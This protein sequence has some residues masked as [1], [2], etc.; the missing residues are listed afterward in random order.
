MPLKRQRNPDK[1]KEPSLV[2]AIGASAG[3]IKVIKELLKAVQKI[4]SDIVFVL[5]QHLEQSGRE[6]AEETLKTFTKLPITEIANGVRLEPGGLYWVPPHTLAQVSK[7]VFKISPARTT[8]QK[9]SVID[10]LFS[11]IGKE[12]KSRSVG[13][14]LSGEGSDGAIGLRN[15]NEAGGLTIVQAPE[16]SEFKSMPE[17]AVATATV[18]HVVPPQEI[19]KLLERNIEYLSAVQDFPKNEN[20]VH[21]VGSALTTICQILFEHTKQD[22][23]HY[24]TSTL[25]RRIQRRMQVLRINT[26]EAYIDRLSQDREEAECLFKELLINVTCFFRD[27]DSFQTLNDE[28]LVDLIKNRKA[29][30]KIR[31]WIAGCSTGEEAYTFAILLREMTAKLKNQPEI[32]ILATDIDSQAL[33]LARRGSYPATIAE[34][35]PA[36]LLNKYFTKRAGRYHVNKELREMV[37]FSIHNLINDP[38]F[39]QLDLISCRN[40]LIYLGSHL[41]KKLFPVFHYALKPNGYLFLGNSESLTSHRELFKP[42]NSK[43]RIAQ[44]KATAIKVPT[45][46]P[47]SIQSYLHQIQETPKDVHADVTMVAQRIALDEMSVKYAVVNE[48]GHIISASEGIGKYIEISGGPFQ[49]NL[50]KLT[51]GSL[52]SVLRRLMATAKAEKRKCVDESSLLKTETGMERVG[53]VVQPMPQLGEESELYWIAFQYLGTVQKVQAQSHRESSEGDQE[54]I[55]QLEREVFVLREQLE[56]SVQD[57]EA[58]NEEL[59][60][61]N[62]ELLSMNEELQAANEELETSKEEVQIANEALQRANIDLENLLAGTQIATLFLDDDLKIRGFTPA[63]TDIYR[64]QANDVGRDIRDF[65][66]HALQ[67]EPFPDPKSV[68]TSVPVESEVLMADGTIYQ[69]RI[70]P[71]TGFEGL[72]E[73]VVVTFIDVT[74]VRNIERQYRELADSMPNI[75]WT[76]TPEGSTDYLNERWYEFTGFDRNLRGESSWLPILHPEDAQR[77]LQA[78]KASLKNGTPFEI[79][80]RFW[81]KRTSTYRWFLGR[82]VP[83]KDQDG[84]IKKWIGTAIDIHDR[85]IA[86]QK[87]RESDRL[88]QLMADTA[89]VLIWI[90]DPAKQRT[91]L[92]KGWIDFTGQTLQQAL[93][94]GWREA[95]HPDDLPLYLSVYEEHSKKRAPFYIEYKLR[96][97]NGEYRWIGAR[98]VPRFAPDGTFEGYIGACLDIHEQKIAAEEIAENRRSLELMIRTSPSFMCVL[99]GPNYT[100]ETVNDQYL[101]L[102]GNRDV[103]GKPIVEALPEVKGQGFIELLD[104]VRTTGKPF[105]G[106]ELPILLQTTADGVV[107]KRYLDFVYQPHLTV[108]GQ[109][110]QIFVHGVDVT[111]KKLAR[112]LI[113]NERENFRNLFKQTPEM[114]CILSGPEHRFE[115]VNE[116]HVRVLGFDATGMTVREAQPESVEVHGILDGVYKTGKTAELREIPVTVTDRLR[117]FNLTYAARRDQEGQTNGIM[118]LGTEV[119]EE[120]LSRGELQKAKQEAENANQMKTLFLANIS[121]EIRTPLAAIFGFSDIL[122]SS[123]LND[124]ESGEYVERISRNAILLRKIIDDLL[125]L[126]KIESDKLEIEWLQADVDSLIEDIY[127]TVQLRAEHKG[128]ELKF[129]WLTAKPKTILTDPLRLSQVLTN[130]IGNAVKFTDKGSIQVD[131]SASSSQLKVRIADTGIGMTAEQQA[132]IFQPFS[133][134]D[135]S[136]TRKFGGTGLG[137]AISMRLAHLIGGDLKLVRSVYGEGSIFELTLQTRCSD[138][139]SNAQE[140]THSREEQDESLEGR[141]ILLVDDTADNRALV[142]LFLKKLKLSVAQAE[143]GLEAMDLLEREEFDLVLMDIQMPKMDGYQSI[144]EIKRRGYQVPVVALTAHSFKAERDRCLEAGFH[145]YITKP[146]DRK[147]L[148]E[149]IRNVLLS[150]RK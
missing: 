74:K 10:H 23:K 126:S 25:L 64:I 55:D 140:A 30:E 148:I 147:L 133:Q 129:N 76:T 68:E 110:E 21:Q 28:V 58:S 6:V 123:S 100:F 16:S 43:C 121:H 119:T 14:I 80:Y 145:G 118:I 40:V 20:I 86:E 61:S 83:I 109:V 52:R 144:A 35:V 107:Q 139:E 114:V 77:S 32:Q 44:R 50:I 62:E 41:Q 115:F 142:S 88:F 31:I 60:S 27:R 143:N 97:K 65:T 59:K 19:A 135:P 37:L 26:V 138:F 120:V 85:V 45:S 128:L 78:R 98:G 2:V 57:L 91:W 7:S 9:L 134:G 101:K 102:V 89:P 84:K 125:D 124:G 103:I 141:K 130:I 71:Y 33:N 5:I 104:E 34:H 24:K 94:D 112:E 53:I 1:L 146:I 54:L 108:N 12:Y 22:F 75:V 137:L 72:R 67:M 117:Y 36:K 149:A 95:V 17:S 127:S 73:G 3:S 87:R 131:F 42:I 79:E 93:G 48:D 47:N 38:P 82:V 18:D 150:E 11:S 122:K 13:I 106:N 66:G 49:N 15:I 4:K 8:D 132:R 51:K 113:E 56:K 92:N 70:L 81:D 46:F 99:R 29:N 116:A 39:S 111:E 105:I 136:I 69:R 96:R 90:A 63:I